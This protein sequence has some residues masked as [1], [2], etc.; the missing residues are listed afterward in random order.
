MYKKHH[1]VKCIVGYI[2]L[3]FRLIILNVLQFLETDII[4]YLF[5]V[6][7]KQQILQQ[8]QVILKFWSVL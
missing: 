8:I 1:Y 5:V 7:M 3:D 6:V 4:M 2:V